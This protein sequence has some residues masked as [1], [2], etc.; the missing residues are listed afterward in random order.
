MTPTRPRVL[1]AL[2][3]GAAVLVA[4]VLLLAEPTLPAVPWT[5]PAALAVVAAGLLAAALSFRRRLRGAPGARPYDP[6]HAARMVVLAKACSHAGALLAGGYVG[7][8]VALLLRSSSP[9]R[10]TDAAL[11]GLSALAALAVL[12]V[13]LLLERFCRVPPDD[14]PDGTAGGGRDVPAPRGPATS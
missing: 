10:R 14:G 7:V 5:L 4:G 1:L 12:A 3:L 6:L 9:E 8:A 11:S 13:G 2:V